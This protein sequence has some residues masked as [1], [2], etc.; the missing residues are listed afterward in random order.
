MNITVYDWIL[1]MPERNLKTIRCILDDGKIYCKSRLIFENGAFVSVPFRNV[2]S[3][4]SLEALNSIPLISLSQEESKYENWRI[5]IVSLFHA[6]QGCTSEYGSGYLNFPCT[7][8]RDLD[9]LTAN[10]NFHHERLA[11]ELYA[12][13]HHAQKDLEWPDHSKFFIKVSDDCAVYRKWI[14]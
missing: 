2:D 3:D 6:Y 13:F 10:Y 14:A 5:K 12:L 9:L 8:K 4:M 11:L 7:P 1:S